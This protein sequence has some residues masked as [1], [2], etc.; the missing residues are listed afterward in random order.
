MTTPALNFGTR[1]RR[2]DKG[3]RPRHAATFAEIVR[4]IESSFITPEEAKHIGCR[5]IRR[6]RTWPEPSSH[7]DKRLYREPNKEERVDMHHL[8]KGHEDGSAVRHKVLADAE[9]P[10]AV[11][12]PQ[13]EAITCLPDE[14][15][16]DD[17]VEGM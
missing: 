7:E 17:A 13:P 6:A 4:A 14:D 15:F 1:R 5:A 2:S 12:V 9:K 10:Q 3:I 11:E 16:P 8:M